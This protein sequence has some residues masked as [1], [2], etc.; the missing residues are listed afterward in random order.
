MADKLFFLDKVDDT[1]LFVDYGCADGTLIKT[2]LPILPDSYFVGYDNSKEMIRMAIDNVGKEQKRATFTS[3]WPFDEK[4][5]SK[6]SKMALILSS[7]IHEVYSYGDKEDIEIFWNRVYKTGFDYICIRD[8]LL[9]R[10][11]NHLAKLSDVM[12]V[13]RANNPHLNE[14][15]EK[16]GEITNQKNLMHFLLK[17]RYS[18]NWVR[19]LGE[20]YI[21]IDLEDIMAT[22]P[23]DY[24]I[25]YV[26]HYVLPFVKKTVMGEFG[27]DLDE[28]THI[29]LI[30]KKK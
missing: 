15:E 5:N 20:N 19:E 17:Y 9:G 2:L 22:I 27:I 1:R 18:K 4:L 7:V 12:K 25:S 24:E 16:W 26:Y 23:K 8:M 21:P 10:H 13:K 3:A 11:S 28:N 29:K 14:F 30:L 6:S